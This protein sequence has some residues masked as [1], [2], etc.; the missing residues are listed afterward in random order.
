MI[1]NPSRMPATVSA[2]TSRGAGR[3]GT[4]A[5]VTT[6]SKSFVFSPSISCCR[7]AV[8]AESAFA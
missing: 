5:V 3:P 1:T 8:S 6:T 4:S 7:R 2:V